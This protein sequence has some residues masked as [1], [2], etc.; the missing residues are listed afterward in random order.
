MKDFKMQT[1]KYN[2]EKLRVLGMDVC[3]TRM[4]DN[5]IPVTA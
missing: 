2:S 4:T 1:L 5:R 3:L